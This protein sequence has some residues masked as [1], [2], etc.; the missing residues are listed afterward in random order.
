MKRKFI[1]TLILSLIVA[2]MAMPTS[3]AFADDRYD[4]YRVN[5]ENVFFCEYDEENSS[6]KPIFKLPK[7]YFVKVSLDSTSEKPDFEGKVYKQV[8]YNGRN[9]YI[10]KD[11]FIEGVNKVTKAT[12]KDLTKLNDSTAY[13]QKTVLLKYEYINGSITIAQDAE[14]IYMG[15]NVRDIDTFYY[16]GNYVSVTN[17]DNKYYEPFQVPDHTFPK[18]NNSNVVTDNSTQNPY[19]NLLTVILI[20]GITIPAVAIVFLIFKPVKKRATYDDGDDDYYED[21]KTRYNAKRRK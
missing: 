16:N 21:Y 6:F 18:D 1:I 3:I 12:S 5:D 2:V 9:G 14:L 7:T 13:F 11:Y 20:I 8:V 4:Y 10:S 19:N 15:K 17:T